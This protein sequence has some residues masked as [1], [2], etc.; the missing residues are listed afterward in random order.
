M[1][2][3]LGPE[4]MARCE[5]AAY[6]P[7]RMYKHCKD[8]FTLFVLFDPIIHKFITS[9]TDDILK[10]FS[11]PETIGSKVMENDEVENQL[12]IEN[13]RTTIRTMHKFRHCTY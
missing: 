8:L 10:T 13:I 5:A 7:E 2:R 4:D 11:K 6:S 1:G 9:Y 12:I 3:L